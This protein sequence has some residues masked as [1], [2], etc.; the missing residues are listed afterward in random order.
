M[1][2]TFEPV[3]TRGIGTLDLTQLAVY[4]AQGG[5]AALRKG[6]H[7]M[8]P[9]TVA[10]AVSRSGLRGR[11]GAGFPTGRK[12]S[13]LPNDGR[14]RYLCCNADE[15]EPGTFKDRML[16]QLHPHQ[17]IEGVLLAAY[18]VQAARSFI[19]IRG[20]FR[21][22][23][24]SLCRALAQARAKG[25][26]GENI[27]GSGW[28]QEIVIHRGAGA[29]ICGEETALL[30]SLEG[31]RGEPRL[32]PPFPAVAG[33]YG[34]PT[35]VNNVETLSCVPHIVARGA[36]WFAGIGPEKSPGPKIFSVSGQVR[37]PGN[38]EL[39]LG[40][41]TRE[42]L[43]H[44]GG[45]FSGRELKAFQPGGGSAGVLLPEHLDVPLDFDS[46]MAAGSMLGSAAVI[47]VDD[48]TCMVR[49]AMWLTQFYANE[50]CGQCTPCRE[51]TNWMYRV[52]RRLEEGGGR[53]EDVQLLESLGKTM[54]G[55]TICVLP[56]AAY[57]FV[58]STLRYFAD[59]YRAHV[60]AHGCPLEVR[61]A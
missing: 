34:M 27:M 43:E 41:T 37:R 4:E 23:Y 1:P 22:G 12:W 7:D 44:A 15:S 38:Y 42:L 5:Y 46:V 21:K 28:S 50:S 57:G 40:T 11:G 14:P 24:E 36:E 31:R 20:E 8:T 10:D 6:L 53:I 32:K 16:L 29:Y 3:L 56:D 54:V 60:T 39:P 25:Y 59:E 30:N 17:I 13:F 19:Y 49:A 45:L 55:T 33:L 58:K 47:V 2:G 9:Q 35:V 51:G 48:S 26:V 18:A 61:S 52:L